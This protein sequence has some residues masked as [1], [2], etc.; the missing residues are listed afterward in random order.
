M[1]SHIGGT[2]SAVL[3]DGV[4]VDVNGVGYRLLMPAG[5]I[6]HLPGTGKKITVQTSL[7]VREDSMTLYGF[8]TADQRD[9]FE[10]LLAVSGIGPKGALAVLSVHSPDALRKA[11]ATEDLEALTLIPGVG[12]KTAA[13]MILELR[14]KLALPQLDV[15]PGGDGAARATLVEVKGA[16]LALEYTPAEARD[17]IERLRD[18][19]IS[20]DEPV[21]D[22]LKRALQ[23]LAR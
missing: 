14:E 19:G 1:I 16:L 13:R 11:I 8:E 12:K 20:D 3:P 6:A 4:V 7:Q 17:A 2:I 10:V 5:V 15:V 22:V 23:G 9:L 18:E 21:A